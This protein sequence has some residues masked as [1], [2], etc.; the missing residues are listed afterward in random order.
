MKFNHSCC[1]LPG[2]RSL[3]FVVLL[4]FFS[5]VTGSLM[6]QEEKEEEAAIQEAVIHLTFSQTDTTRIC[7]ALV[8]AGGKPVQEKEVHFYIKRMYSLLPVGSAVETDTSGTAI[9]EYPLDMPGDERGQYTVVAKIEDDDTFGTV[10]EA[11]EVKWGVS[12]A[13]EHNRWEH[14]SLSASR[15]HAPTYLILVSNL[16][17]A[18]I[19][20]VLLYVV[21]QVFRIRKESRLINIKK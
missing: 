19:W 15:E 13:G 10:E 16:I 14:R 20:G 7:T 3:F 12:P 4:V 21:I 17:I 11:A 9:M 5:G 8:T 6:A 1:L 2:Y 18:V